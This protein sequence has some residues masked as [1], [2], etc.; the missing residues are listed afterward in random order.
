MSRVNSDATR[1]LSR[2]SRRLSA[3]RLD[4][5]PVDIGRLRAPVRGLAK[6]CVLAPLV[7]SACGAMNGWFCSDARC[8]WTDT[9]WAWVG[10][11]ANPPDPP[12]DPTDRFLWQ[13][14]AMSLGQA[15]YFDTQFSGVATQVDAIKRTSP[16]GSASGSCPARPSPS[17]PR[18]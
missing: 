9:E 12:D 3:L 5:W 15:F 18:S 6:V 16:P 7:L 17:A 14:G 11:L 1:R 4:S 2:S 13:V 8:E 10:S